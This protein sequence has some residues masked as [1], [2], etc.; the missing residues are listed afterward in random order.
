MIQWH[1]QAGNINT[2]LKV[3]VD[4]NVPELSATNVA[5]WKLYADY[6]TKGRYNITLGRDL[7]TELL[8]NIKFSDHVIKYDDGPL[9][10]S[11]APMVDLGPYEFKYLNIGEFTPR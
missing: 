4:F 2:N 10:G 9:K 1:T 8:L 3:K 5:T 6:Y 11:T 7:S